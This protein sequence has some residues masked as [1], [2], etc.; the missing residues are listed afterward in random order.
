VSHPTTGPSHRYAGLDGLRAI[1]VVLV[2][3]YHLF[4]GAGVPGGFLG[5]DVFFV[6]SGFLI[7]SLLLVEHDSTGRIRVGGF[8]RRRARRLLPALAIAIVVCA[9]AAW[10]IGGDILVRLGAQVFGAATFSYNWVAL[11]EGSDYFSG[12]AP[13]LLRNVWSLAVEEQFY[14]VWPAM[15]LL[16]LVV[17]SPVVRAIIAV[18][19]ATASAVWM[20]V[21]ASADGVTRAYYGTD[22]HASGLLIG[23]ALAFAMAPLLARARAAAV[24]RPTAPVRLQGGWTVVMPRSAPPALPAEESR[25]FRTRTVTGLVGAVAVAGI[26]VMALTVPDGEPAAFPWAFVGVSLLT[27]AV[28]AS[29]VW[30]HSWIG[31]VL[32]ARPLRWIGT[33][34]YGIYLWHWPL[35]VLLVAAA[36]RT[37]P[38]VAFPPIIGLVCLAATAVAAILSYRY[39]EQPVRA[40][41]LGGA[42]R[43][44]GTRLRGT[45]G[46]RVAAAVAVS[47]VVML[48]GGTGIAVAVAPTRSAAETSIDAG[49]AAI[50]D[51]DAAPSP[52]P[53]TTS[54]PDAPSPAPTPPPAAVPEPA[55][56]PIAGSEVTAIGDSVM[57]ASA[58][59]LM[60]RLPGIQIDAQVS[61]S[62][63]AAPGILQRLAAAGQLRHYVVIGLGTNGPVDAGVLQTIAGIVGPG[64][65]L[66]LV[67]AFAP[68]SWIPGV[69]AELASFAGSHPG[70][71]VADWAGAIAGHVELLA[72]DRIHPGA[73]GGRIYADTLAGTLDGVERARAE[74]AAALQRQEQE[75]YR[76]EH[77]PRHP[78]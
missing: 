53:T 2:V 51:A 1:A 35:L 78:S 45:G 70:T 40:V 38:D 56:T 62:L 9:T 61:R 10:V 59:G 75:A 36:Q 29:C 34:S 52:A 72:G 46:H 26:V 32:D 8:W 55:P 57:L 49:I 4:P 31:P 21:A 30:P 37:G 24:E 68:R 60:A 33:R 69:N 11:A 77:S 71:V 13:E 48:V 25:R 74:A 73:A 44:L 50:R 22:T 58:Q 66:V 18:G 16:L 14:L 47:A 42:L 23:T 76:R 54:T 43:G 41:G 5:V 67:N 3:V 15:L 63:W 20:G 65:E 28:I 64:R 39:V 27:A 17:R 12:S 6:I 19:M 7:T